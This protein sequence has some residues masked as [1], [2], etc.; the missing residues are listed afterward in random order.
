MEYIPGIKVSEVAALDE[1]GFDRKVIASHG[2]D[3]ILEQVFKHGF[4]HADPH[5]GNVFILPGDIIC[6]LDYGMMGTVDRQAREDFA[7]ILQGVVRRDESKIVQSLLK[8]VEWDVEPDRRALE[9]DI[10]DYYGDVFA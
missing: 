7:D 10:A 1:K 8:I 4:F 3:L 9:R 5:P 6:Y 2:A